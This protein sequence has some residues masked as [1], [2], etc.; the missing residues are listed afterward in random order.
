MNLM[1]KCPEEKGES[2][3]F[4]PHLITQEKT[5]FQQDLVMVFN[6]LL[7][8]SSEDHLQSALNSFAKVLLVSPYLT[9]NSAVIEGMKS[10]G[11]SKAICSVSVND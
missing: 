6:K 3:F 7:D 2:L 10:V 8:I 4:H 1:L 9:L 11:H 5:S